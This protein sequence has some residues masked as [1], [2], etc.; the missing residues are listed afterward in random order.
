MLGV[1]SLVLLPALMASGSPARAVVVPACSLT[2]PACAEASEATSR[3]LA[4]ALPG[5]TVEHAPAGFPLTT[6]LAAALLAALDT[7]S[8]LG[9]LLPVA[10]DL[11][12]EDVRVLVVVAPQGDHG[13][14][15]AAL[16]L[17]PAAHAR[18]SVTRCTARPA[19]AEVVSARLLQGLGLVSSRG[20]TVADAACGTAAR[21]RA[22]VRNPARGTDELAGSLLGPRPAVQVAAVGIG[23]VAAVAG[24][25]GVGLMAVSGVLRA[26][27]VVGPLV[28]LTPTPGLVR[29]PRFVALHA[30]PVVG[31]VVGLGLLMLG[32]AGL[33]AALTLGGLG[34][35]S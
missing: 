35:L 22:S 13:M 10:A 19:A 12:L 26:L 5:W 20:T 1:W 27:L 18:T 17:Q 4:A 15:G 7:D 23:A 6:P 11:N 14:R 33:A 3:A 8:A 21:A 16:R 29:T 34:A 28:A 24:L 2:D 32:M 31:A 30:P 9:V 25:A